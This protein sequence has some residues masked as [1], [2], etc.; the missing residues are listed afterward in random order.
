MLNDKGSWTVTDSR[1]RRLRHT[2]FLGNDPFDRRTGL[3]ADHTQQVNIFAVTQLVKG[4]D[5]R[6]TFIYTLSVL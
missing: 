2:D 5:I 6:K 1:L 3:S 4:L